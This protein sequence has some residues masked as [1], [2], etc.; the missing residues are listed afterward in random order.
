VII[1]S[2]SLNQFQS[3][4][5]FP[6]YAKLPGSQNGYSYAN[7]N[8][9][10]FTDPSG[11]DAIWCTAEYGVSSPACSSSS[12]IE[13][14]SVSGQHWSTA[15]KMQ[16]EM[17][18]KH[19]GQ[20][21]AATYNEYMYG[22]KLSPYLQANMYYQY[23]C[24]PDE[25]PLTP[26][27]AFLYFYG[28]RVLFYK[29]GTQ[30]RGAWGRYTAEDPMPR[31]GIAVYTDADILSGIGGYRW[32]T[33][34]MGHY[35]EARVNGILGNSTVRM[36]LDRTNDQFHIPLRGG[37]DDEIERFGTADIEN[38]SYGFA[39]TG[40]GWQQ[41]NYV[42]KVDLDS[43]GEEFADMFLG[44]NYNRWAP[45]TDLTYYDVGQARSDFMDHHMARWIALVINHEKDKTR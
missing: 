34:E 12:L 42:S 16:V 15:E 2:P 4:D 17:A 44:W 8:P 26:S 33:H 45:I 28:G 14:D 32:A 38:I 36:A 37:E 21:L 19:I 31:T 7:N 23:Y 43:R 24:G 40:Y 22:F 41:S 20:R 27:E 35:F 9:I 25:H 18:A 29:T 6:G 3:R 10:N 5:P 13:F 39:D 1:Y 11:R 30:F